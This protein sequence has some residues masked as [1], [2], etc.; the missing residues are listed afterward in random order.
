MK[1]KV[2]KVNEEDNVLVAL[3]DLSKGETISYNG[4]EYLLLENR[5]KKGWDTSGWWA[6]KG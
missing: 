4:S 2:L 3:T 1:R 5:K 6:K